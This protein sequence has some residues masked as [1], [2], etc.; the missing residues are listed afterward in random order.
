MGKEYMGI[1][2]VTYL[3]NEEGVIEKVWPKVSPAGHA[4]DILN[5]LQQKT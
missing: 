3:I 1:N 2:R 4:E 5:Y